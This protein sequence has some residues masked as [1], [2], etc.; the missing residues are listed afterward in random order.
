[1]L[2]RHS[3]LSAGSPRTSEQRSFLN[4]EPRPSPPFLLPQDSCIVGGARPL[5]WQKGKTVKEVVVTA[6][7]RTPI[8]SYCGSLRDIPVEN[9]SAIVLNESLARAN[10]K[11][12]EVD[13]VIMSQ[14]YANGEA[15]NL[16]RMALLT[17]GWPVEIPG[18]TLDRRCC[19]GIQA[20]WNAA[21][22]IQTGNAEIVVAGGAESMS[23]SEFYIPGE[24]LKWGVGGRTDSKWGFAPRGHG[25]MNLWGMPIYDRIQ[26]GRPQSQ[27][28]DRFGE[29]SSMMVWAEAAARNENISREEA[30]S[31]ALRSHQRAVAAIDTGKFRDEIVAVAVTKKE[32]A[33]SFD[34]DETPRRDTSMEK[35]ARLKPI[36][37]DGVCTAGNSSSENDGAVA[38]VLMTPETAEKHGVSPIVYI[39]SFGVAGAD[40]MLTYPA[41]PRSVDVALSKAGLTIKDM[42]IV[43]IQEAFAAQALADAKLVKLEAGELDDK[44][45]VNG[46]GVSLGHPIGATGG[47]R[48][49]TMAYEMMRRNL[50]YGLVTIC[51]G[52]GLGISAVVERR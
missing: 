10:V 47:M 42:D 49:T 5:V 34:T 40:P 17:A 18:Y 32:G 16:A 19:S 31:W 12:E 28:W 8:A 27:P 2:G 46:S 7:V 48:L 39:K 22:Q 41:V 36:Y 11:P 14:A 33:D 52:G 13:E 21:M 30:D 38:T 43:E 25:N 23:R 29:L 51:G 50:R 37:A 20:I 35:L 44:V 6:A 4:A 45:N 24:Y 15:S 26:R 9:L 1:M 3:L